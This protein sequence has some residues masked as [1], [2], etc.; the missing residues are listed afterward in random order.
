MYVYFI[1]TRTYRIVTQYTEYTSDVQT[2]ILINI[3]LLLFQKHFA[4]NN[5]NVLI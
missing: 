3:L 4:R 5:G 2:N 1:I